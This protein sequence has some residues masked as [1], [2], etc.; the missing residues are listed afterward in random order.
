MQVSAK[1][2][3]LMRT[4]QSKLSQLIV[5]GTALVLASL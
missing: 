5:D 4:V 1:R 2:E 3:K